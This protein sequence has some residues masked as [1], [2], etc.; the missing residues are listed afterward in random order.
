MATRTPHVQE[1]GVPFMNRPNCVFHVHEISGIR[2][3]PRSFVRS[4][5]G[6]VALAVGFS[7]SDEEISRAKY[8]QNIL[9]ARTSRTRELEYEYELENERQE[10]GNVTSTCT[11]PGKAPD[12]ARQ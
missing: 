3:S 4:P 6:E 8:L 2:W 10:K 12:P 11:R 1:K 5:W 9:A 7:L